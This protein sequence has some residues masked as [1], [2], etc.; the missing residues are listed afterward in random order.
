MSKV[1]LLTLREV[2]AQHHHDGARGP[3]RARDPHALLQ[4]QGTLARVCLIWGDWYVEVGC[5]GLI[6]VSSLAALGRLMCRCWLH[7]TD[8]YVDIG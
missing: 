7:G 4:R 2:R 8:S 5:I 1:V 3:V 6:G